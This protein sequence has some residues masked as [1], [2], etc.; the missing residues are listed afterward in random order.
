MSSIRGEDRPS[1]IV[2]GVT[3]VA[4]LPTN[5]HEEDPTPSSSEATIIENGG[6][7]DCGTGTTPLVVP[8]PPTPANASTA[9]G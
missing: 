8:L 1:T 5:L 7:D 4:A 6:D 3:T 9:I 2:G